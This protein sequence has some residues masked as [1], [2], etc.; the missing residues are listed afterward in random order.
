MTVELLITLIVG[1]ILILSLHS[2]VTSHT[3]LTQRSRSLVVANAYAEQKVEALRSA[4]YLGTPNGTTSV[5]A[6]LPSDLKKPRTGTLEITS[7][8]TAIKK[9]RLTIQYNEQG[10]SRTQSYTTYIGELGVGQY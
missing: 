1:A 4:G 9:V 2:I 3:Y 7:P 8:T 10:A 5:T 6:E